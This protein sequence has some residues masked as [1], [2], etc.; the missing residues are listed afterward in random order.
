MCAV[1][2]LE[3]LID[4]ARRCRTAVVQHQR[5]SEPLPTSRLV[6]P[7]QITQPAGE[8]TLILICWQLVPE[9]H[10][11]TGWRRLRIDCIKDVRDGG[12]NFSARAEI[13]MAE[14]MIIGHRI[15]YEPDGLIEAANEYY[16]YVSQAAERG[17]ITEPEA[18]AARRIASQI[19]LEQIR[20]VHAQ[21]LTDAMR[22][23]I[24]LGRITCLERDR[25]IGVRKVL[26]RLGWHP[27]DKDDSEYM[28]IS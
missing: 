18:L 14:G 21:V 26:K 20:G 7:H 8:E 9:T 2:L 10:G 17:K 4:L 3:S 27:G 19:S 12:S 15:A 24:T 23:F 11:R 22:P 6:E 13:T 25:L 28:V 1:E 5:F 16:S